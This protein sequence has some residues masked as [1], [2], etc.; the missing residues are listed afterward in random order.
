[1]AVSFR[2]SP[3]QF[4]IDQALRIPPSLVVDLTPPISC[5]FFST[6]LWPN[7]FWN[8][9]PPGRKGLAM[10]FSTVA[11]FQP[12]FKFTGHAPFTLY[13]VAASACRPPPHAGARLF[14]SMAPFLVFRTLALLRRFFRC[15][16]FSPVLYSTDKSS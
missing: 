9:P 5:F 14:L 16:S 10:L 1:M 6:M 15:M 3:I 4:G 7:R 13:R 11:E 8:V 12:F 2:G